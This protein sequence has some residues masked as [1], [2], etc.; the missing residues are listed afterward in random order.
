MDA[1]GTSDTLGG[2]KYEY[3]GPLIMKGTVSSSIAYVD[4]RS[5]WK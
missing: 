1:V 5:S 4:S 3:A 2:E